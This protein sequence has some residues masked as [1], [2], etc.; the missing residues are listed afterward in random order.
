MPVDRKVAAHYTHGDLAGAILVGLEQAGKDPDNLA[1]ADLAPV[2]ELHV[3][4]R[5]ATVEFAARLEAGTG[6]HLLDIG[7]GIGGPARHF[8]EERGC[9][10]TGIDLTEEFCQVAAMLTART[11]LAE[12]IHY[13]QASALALP[14]GESSFDGAYTIHVAMNIADKSA[15]YAEARRVVKPGGVFGLYDVLQGPGGAPHYPV[16]WA[17]DPSTSF[18]VTIEE[19][20]ALLE[21]AGFEV[22]AQRDRTRFGVAFFRE[23]LA[24]LGEG[25]PPPLGP[26]IIM[27]ETYREKIANTLRNMEEA[28]V[29]PWEVICRRV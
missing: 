11:G 24:R 4:G 9:H 5:P 22:L 2:D 18:L 7:C 23:R 25:A 14:F 6:M 15:L 8:A 3:G 13:R 29:A 1:L 27:G 20:R 17:Q 12:R 28:R 10:V 16:P 26:Q 21:G 19:L